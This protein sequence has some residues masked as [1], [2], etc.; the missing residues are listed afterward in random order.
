MPTTES[1]NQRLGINHPFYK[2]VSDALE[3]LGLIK[4]YNPET[5]KRLK[6]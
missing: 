5:K 4:K 6:K 2:K 1:V 3:K